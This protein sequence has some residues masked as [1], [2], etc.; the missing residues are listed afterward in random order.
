MSRYLTPSK[1]GLLILIELY[2]ESNISS[3]AISIVSFILSHLLSHTPKPHS[4]E[5]ISYWQFFSHTLPLT[6]DLKSF[7]LL[8]AFHPASSSFQ[9][10]TLWDYFQK[11]LW[12]IDSLDALHVF[13]SRR[14]NLLARTHEEIKKDN[15]MGIPLPSEDMIL[16]SRTSPLGS[17]IRKSSI[18]FERLK[19]CDSVALWTAFNRWRYGDKYDHTINKEGFPKWVGNMVLNEQEKHKGKYSVEKL[20]L[21]VH[22]SMELHDT[23]E[24]Y[25]STDDVGKLLEFQVEKMQ[26]KFPHLSVKLV[27]N[28]K[29]SGIE[30]LLKS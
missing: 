12:D 10:A 29:D 6:L 13:F 14:T 8:L 30:F 5:S 21:I 19:F 22:S 25:V 23:S 9:C 1:I 4:P 20:G 24:S 28:F 2:V 7:E 26:S 11:K 15:E 18:E 16:L 17:F 3:S 27:F